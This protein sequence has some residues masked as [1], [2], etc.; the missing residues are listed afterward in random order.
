MLFALQHDVLFVLSHG[1]GLMEDAIDRFLELGARKECD[2]REVFVLSAPD[3]PGTVLGKTHVPLTLGERNP[4]HFDLF[5]I[6]RVYS[7][8]SGDAL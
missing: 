2:T 3:Y 5:F 8:V 1:P 6:A 4:D 7:S